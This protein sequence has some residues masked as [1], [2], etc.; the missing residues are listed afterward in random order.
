MP[1]PVVTEG[2]GNI[3]EETG[4]FVMRTL[5]APFIFSG[6]LLLT[7][8]PALAGPVTD[9][10]AHTEVVDGCDHGAS[11]KICREDPQGTRGKDCVVHGK[12]GGRNEDHCQDIVEHN[13]T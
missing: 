2:T 4:A 7:S 13:E 3:E 11:A 6:V 9:E 12:W 1:A 5:I 10:V 8:A